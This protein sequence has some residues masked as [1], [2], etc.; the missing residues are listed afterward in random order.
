MIERQLPKNQPGA[1]QVDDRRQLISGLRH[2]LR[3]VAFRR[4][5]TRYDKL[6]ANFLSGARCKARRSRQQCK[7]RCGRQSTVRA[8]RNGRSAR[9]TSKMERRND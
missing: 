9:R 2:V 3:S 1:G 7:L 8:G 5:A 6:A 4:A